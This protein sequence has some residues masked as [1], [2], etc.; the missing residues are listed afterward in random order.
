MLDSLCHL[1]VF[2]KGTHGKLDLFQY[3]RILLVTI[4]AQHCGKTSHPHFTAREKKNQTKQ[5]GKH[6]I[7]Q[8]QLQTNDMPN[9]N[10][11]KGPRN[12]IRVETPPVD[13][14]GFLPTAVST[15]CRG[16]NI[17]TE[18]RNIPGVKT[19]IRSMCFD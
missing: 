4:T 15:S 5:K 16:Q 8:Q 12:K 11:G 1:F 3:R 17:A 13:G 18:S 10:T 19:T 2:F 7:K 9:K 6:S 14:I